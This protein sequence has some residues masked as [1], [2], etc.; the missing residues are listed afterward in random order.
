MRF[1]SIVLAVIKD[2]VYVIISSMIFLLLKN[3]INIECNSN[4]SVCMKR[5][6][7]FTCSI[8]HVH[9]LTTVN[10]SNFYCIML[11]SLVII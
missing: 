2:T 5:S 4:L 1:F 6:Y 9:I 7:N 3:N 11:Y 10:F 8:Q